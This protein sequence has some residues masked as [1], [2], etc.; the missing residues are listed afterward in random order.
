VDSQ[1]SSSLA[2]PRFSSD[3]PFL[4]G[5]A[6]ETSA[7]TELSGWPG[8]GPAGIH[9][10]SDP[11]LRGEFVSHGCIRNP[12]AAALALQRSAPGGT[13]VDLIA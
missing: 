10:T 2:M 1:P 9:G 8:R 4:A 7:Y 3:D 6:L 12:T 11:W 5:F 13:V